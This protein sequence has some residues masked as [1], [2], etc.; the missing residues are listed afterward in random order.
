ML[1]KQQSQCLR[2]IE[3]TWAKHGFCPSYDEIKDELGLTSKSSVHRIV[4]ALADRGFIEVS[5]QRRSIKVLR[6]QSHLDPTYL[7]GYRDG[8]AAALKKHKLKSN[9]SED[10]HDPILRGQK[11]PV[12]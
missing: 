7:K 5:D 3:K 8:Y 11:L 12:S 2:Y 9:A 6:P 4:H 1:T 10:L